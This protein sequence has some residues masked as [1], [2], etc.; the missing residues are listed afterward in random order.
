MG[1]EVGTG[2]E[3][4]RHRLGGPDLPGRKLI[5]RPDQIHGLSGSPTYIS[6]SKC[7]VSRSLT[8][9][10]WCTP[11]GYVPTEGS[12]DGRSDRQTCRRGLGLPAS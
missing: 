2:P 11:W 10:T 8:H 5:M 6:V 12:P 1:H 4:V 7:S 3:R 9:H